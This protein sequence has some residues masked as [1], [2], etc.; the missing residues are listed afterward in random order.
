MTWKIDQAK[1]DTARAAIA[2][3]SDEF[4]DQY[5]DWEDRGDR[6]RE[7]DKGVTVED[8]ITTA[9]DLID[10]IEQA[11]DGIEADSGV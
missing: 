2:A 9:Q 11:L 4:T 10:T 1:L 7:S 8:W 3:L 6:W 5:S